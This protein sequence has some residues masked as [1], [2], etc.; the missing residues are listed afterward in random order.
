MKRRSLIFGLLIVFIDQITKLSIDNSFLLGETLPLVKGFLY[1]TKV[2]NTGASWS[3]FQGMLNMLIVISLAAFV[4]LVY[5]QD[6][7]KINMRNILGFGFIYG[8]LFGNLVDRVGHKSVID[9]IHLKFGTYD[10]PIFNFADVA[11]VIGT[12]LIVISLWK[13]DDKYGIKSTRRKRK[14]TR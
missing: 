7:F 3:M 14:K 6:F 10:F 11:L 13:G 4:C 5:Y 2:Y 12:I 9:F 8:G 1:I